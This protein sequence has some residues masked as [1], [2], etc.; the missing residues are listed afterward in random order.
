LRVEVDRLGHGARLIALHG[1]GSIL[2]HPARALAIDGLVALDV[3][4]QPARLR[5]ELIPLLRERAA[6]L[7]GH[8]GELAE[9]ARLLAPARALLGALEERL[10]LRGDA[11]RRLGAVRRILREHGEA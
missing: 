1:G 3:L 8:L 6:S 7:H 5:E 9:A 11:L 2:E 4:Q 10:R